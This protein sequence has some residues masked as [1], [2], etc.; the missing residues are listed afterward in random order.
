[1]AILSTAKIV[2]MLASA[3][4]TG[5]QILNAAGEYV[6]EVVEDFMSGF[7]GH[8][9]KIWEYISGKWKLEIDSIV[10]R[11]T[12]TVFEL[13]IQKIRAVKG[14]LGITQAN[15]K[16]KSAI[17]DDAKQNWLI[18][19]EED[20]MSFVAHDIIRCQNWQNGTLK[21]YWVEISEIR[22]I[23]GVDTIVI[24]VSEF[25]GSIDY[26][27]GMEAVVSGLSDMSIPTEG[28]EIIQ[29]GNT[30]NI[31]RQSAIYLH[32][33]EGG[34]PAIDILFGIN[35]KSFA[36]CV[37]MR[38]GGDIPGANGLKGFYCENG[39]I[40]GTDSSGHTVYC[41]YPDGTAEFG[42][43][44][45]RF[46]TDKSG[47]IA[48][49]AI[50]WKW[51]DEKNKFVCTM[52][53]VILG[54]D[55]L[56]PEAKENLKGDA[57]TGIESID[58]EY[59][60]NSSGTEAPT[61]GWQTTAPSWENGKYIWS[62]TRIKLTDGT[63]S[64]TEAACISGGKG[65]SSIVEQY[66]LS[67]SSSSLAD[68]DWSTERP[69]WKNGWYVWTR[70]VITYTDGTSTT[71]EAVCVTGEKGQ[72]GADGVNGKD[73]TSIV[74]QGSFVSHPANPQ[75]GWAYRN[76]TDGKSYVYQD[77][78][79]YQMT[80]DGVDGANGKDGTNGLSIVWKGDLSTPPANPEIN[81]VYR[82]IDNGKVYIYTGTAWALM[83]ADGNDGASGAD[84]SDG[85]SVFITYHDGESQPEVPT[86]D[87]TLN[88]WHTNATDSV[89]WMSQKVAE[90]ASSGSWGNPIKIKGDKGEDGA[91]G[92]D[93]VMF[94]IEFYMNG[95]RVSDIP[96]D[97]HGTSISGNTVIAKLLR[98]SGSSK[99][100]YT[101]DR[102]RVSYLKEGVEVLS[103][104]P[105]ESLNFI[106]ISLEKSLEYDSI[107]VMAYEQSIPYYVL[108]TEASI[109]KVMANVPDWLI[110]WDTNKVQIGSNYMIS[111]KLFTGKN[112]GTAEEPI[113]TGIV[114]GDKCITIN[115]VERSGIFALVNNEVMFE[116]D[117][118][119]QKYKFNGEVNA[120]SG[121]FKNIQSPNGSFNIDEVGNISIIGKIS[122]S[123][124]DTR[125]EI[126]PDT[127]SLSMYNQ[128]NNEVGRIFF[129]EEDW[130]EGKNY[131]PKI[132]L[133]TY[134]NDVLNAEMNISSAVISSSTNMGDDNY[135][136]YIDPR[137]GLRF[138]KNDVLTNTY[139]AS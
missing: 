70:S 1:M 80:I 85:L 68:G 137:S 2:G 31:N 33:D 91:D 24:P 38:I 29:F 73:G 53:D 3:K 43:G 47:Y 30:I 134:H 92:Q 4:K 58:V 106:N 126:D 36:G 49:G 100:D 120:T 96:C 65:I 9:W 122:T 123:L 128:D 119:S 71:T 107:A 103:I 111:P 34:Q 50:S 19:I 88:G 17:L 37:K 61:L 67:S 109:S 117:P 64:Y 127:N 133:R 90:S 8:G 75:N 125:I 6:A 110:G 95:I 32:A 12:M 52:G 40:K 76:T 74:W 112:T 77:G 130:T 104:Q 101:P 14:A 94:A 22:K 136:F 60:K 114:Q 102:W 16:I 82:D 121:V 44:S 132:R 118:E 55:N 27:D 45:A 115:G 89:V 63:I 138:Y 81:W 11:E 84:G 108:I 116:L 79:W 46:A 41:I 23:D 99:E 26:I 39:L 87:G 28:D 129:V 21:G 66:Y 54:W 72:N 135:F 51:D 105:L 56:S 98:I 93:A 139:P 15:G 124:N 83:V 131:Y 42:D 62:R 113:L 18:T 59:S 10:V 5:K 86:E 69:A 7:A 25:S 97:I 35:S 57:G 48:G 78:V 20:E 13:L